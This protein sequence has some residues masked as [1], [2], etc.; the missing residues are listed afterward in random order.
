MN[1]CV[2]KLYLVAVNICIAYTFF[3]LALA[4]GLIHK[5]HVSSLFEK[6][7][8]F[9]HLSTLEREMGFRTEMVS[10]EGLHSNLDKPFSSSIFYQIGCNWFSYFCLFQ[11]LYYSYFKTVIE[12]PSFLSGVG[13]LMRNNVTEYPHTIN[14]LKRFNLYPEVHSDYVIKL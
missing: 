4:V 8:H 10:T 1:I 2:T 3:I 5:H 12:A 6:D 14:T 9:S 11:G 13:S 7:R